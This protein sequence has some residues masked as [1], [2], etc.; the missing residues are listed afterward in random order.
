MENEGTIPACVWFYMCCVDD[1]RRTQGCRESK[2]YVK[3]L[4]ILWKNFDLPALMKRFEKFISLIIRLDIGRRSP[5][6]YH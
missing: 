6:M 1:T 2:K 5:C 3:S 4:S